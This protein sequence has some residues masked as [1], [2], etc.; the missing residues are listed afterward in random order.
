MIDHDALAD[1]RFCQHAPKQHY[2][3]YGGNSAEEC[4]AAFLHGA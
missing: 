4:C 3:R 2:G 1:G